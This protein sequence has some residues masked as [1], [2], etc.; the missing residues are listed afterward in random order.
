MNIT[1]VTCIEA[2]HIELDVLSM[3]R[4]L[5]KWG[6]PLANAPVVAVT[7]RMGPPLRSES[8]RAMKDLGIQHVTTNAAQ[9]HRYNW[10][11]FLNK[12]ITLVAAAPHIHTEHA[13]W[14]DGDIII[15]KTPQALLEDD[16]IEFMACVEEMGPISTG[17][18]DKFDSFWVKAAAAQGIAEKD[19]AWVTAPFSQKKIR[20]YINSGVFRYKTKQGLEEDYLRGFE[21]LLD[22]RIMPKDDPSIFLHEQISLAL[23][24][25]GRKRPYRELPMEYN[26]HVEPV[27]ETLYRPEDYGKAVVFHYHRALRSP[28]H[29]A[30][31]ID[32]V[33]D[34]RPDIAQFVRETTAGSDPTPVW[35]RVFRRG[36][37]KMRK[38][39]ERQ[40][41]ETVT[42]V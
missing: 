22:A 11:G 41:M 15:A 35:W 26:F 29:R 32:L 25:G 24:V 34:I 42:G 39:K 37:G 31:F 10:N 21:R 18:A 17:P 13:L 23:T 12:P 6:G 9:V 3:V 36:V 14:L 16:E 33:K 20:S 1:V 8:K 30:R 2:G 27:Y 19:I 7:P 4:S 28:E 5:R 38:K 40:F